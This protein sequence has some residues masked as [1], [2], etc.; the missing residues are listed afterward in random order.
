MADYVD[1]WHAQLQA[2]SSPSP[3]L[4]VLVISAS[5]LRRGFEGFTS[6][7]TLR[8]LHTSTH[9][10]SKLWQDLRASQPMTHA[11]STDKQTQQSR[12]SNHSKLRHRLPPKQTHRW[13]HQPKHSGKLSRLRGGYLT[14]SPHSVASAGLRPGRL[15]STHARRL[16]DEPLAVRRDLPLPRD[17]RALLL[18]DREQRLG[19]L[20]DLHVGGLGLLRAGPRNCRWGARG[21]AWPGSAGAR[22]RCGARR[23]GGA[24]PG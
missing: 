12:T 11:V 24:S 3:G 9:I 17:I 21:R 15:V 5:W 13:Q 4:S 20:Q 10:L 18:Q 19:A 7:V 22:G 16:P 14:L 2:L 6:A 23:R 8:I 1:Q